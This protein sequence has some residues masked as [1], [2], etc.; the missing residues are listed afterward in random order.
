MTTYIVLDIETGICPDYE[1]TLKDKE[2]TTT[3]KAA[4]PDNIPVGVKKKTEPLNTERCNEWLAAQE[5]RI[6]QDL[7]KQKS[8]DYSQAALHWTTGRIVSI[9]A[10]DLLKRK[11]IGAWTGDNEPKIL[12]EFY[13][14]LA[15]H[16]DFVL[17]GANTD[18]F[19]KPFLIGRSMKWN[20]GLPP[21]LR[22][23]LPNYVTDVFKIFGYAKH[24]GQ[25]CGL[26]RMS[27]A[28]GLKSKL[29]HG[30]DVAGLL[31]RISLGE[32]DLWK[33]IKEYNMG[34]VDITATILERYLKD[35]IP[36]AK[37]NI[38]EVS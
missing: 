15:A 30:S 33:D 18:E 28:L 35:F 7:H 34:D 11:E 25:R 14:W 16:T 4:I 27:E 24:S 8:D 32:I 37:K 38:G 26:Q 36:Q 31:D 19:D 20:L 13:T 2:Y 6:K 10:V 29:M 23:G 22:F 1:K 3:L 21:A 17:S 12:S 9:S 5:E